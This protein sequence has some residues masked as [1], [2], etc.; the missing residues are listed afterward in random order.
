MCVT[1]KHGHTY[2]SVINQSWS[3]TIDLRKPAISNTMAP[4]AGHMKKQHPKSGSQ[5]RDTENISHHE[6][7]KSVSM[8][9]KERTEANPQS[10]GV[11]EQTVM[12]DKL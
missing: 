10:W 4:S 12:K 8:A 1:N 3:K 11:A 7:D 2:T 6:T 5:S 9:L